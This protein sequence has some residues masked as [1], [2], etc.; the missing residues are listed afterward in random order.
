MSG[1]VDSGE[2]ISAMKMKNHKS[3]W[4]NIIIRPTYKLFES[5]GDAA[6]YIKFLGLE[7]WHRLLKNKLIILTSL[8]NF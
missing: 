4:P 2:E 8:F 7:K 3:Q 1:V 5:I 6:L